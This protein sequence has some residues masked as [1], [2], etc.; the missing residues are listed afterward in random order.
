MEETVFLKIVGNTPMMRIWDFLLVE[1]GLFDY[2]MTDIAENSHVSWTKFNEIF[3]EFEKRGIVKQTRRIGKARLF[4]LNEDN[5]F[6][7]AMIELHK[8]ISLAVLEKQKPEIPM[9][10]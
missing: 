6:T 2:S 9:S 8:K 7:K 4:M 3:P 1:R 10:V 5:P